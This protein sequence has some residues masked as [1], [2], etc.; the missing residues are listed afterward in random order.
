MWRRLALA[1]YRLVPHGY[2]S[3]MVGALAV[4]II[5][6]WLV[7][8]WQSTGDMPSLIV[9]GGLVVAYAAFALAVVRIVPRDRL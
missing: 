4:L 9:A 1:L 6:W 8:Y 7:T 3:L 5:A 2:T